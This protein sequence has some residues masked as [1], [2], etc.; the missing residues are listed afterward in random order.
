MSC[1]SVA[2]PSPWTTSKRWHSFIRLQKSSNVPARRPPAVS[3]MFGGPD[4]TANAT[5]GLD[6]GTWRCGSTEC[7]VMRRGGEGCADQFPRKLYDL[8][9]LVDLG[10]GVSIAHTR[11]R[12]QHLHA[13]RLED[14][15]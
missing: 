13:L 15:E 7:S 4:V 11:I 5:Q 9:R 8:R 2:P 12:G 10:T 3:M 14:D 6:S 1:G